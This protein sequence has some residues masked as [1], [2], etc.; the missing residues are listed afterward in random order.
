MPSLICVSG[1]TGV[2]KSTAVEY[3][4]SQCSGKA[5][6]LGAAVLEEIRRRRMPETRDSERIVRLELRRED[7]AALVKLKVDTI[8]GNLRR[9]VPVIVDAIM[10]IEEYEFLSSLVSGPCPSL[11][12]IDAPIAERCERLSRRHCRAFTF[13]EI[14]ARDKTEIETLRIDRVFTAAIH[15]IVNDRSIAEFRASLDKFLEDFFL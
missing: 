6:Y 15:K 10:N 14:G 4:E 5:V 11:L 9:G 8:S 2:C 3:M 1:F 12:A 7:P 13:D